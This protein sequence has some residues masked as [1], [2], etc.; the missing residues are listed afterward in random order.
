MNNRPTLTEMAEDLERQ[1]DAIDADIAEAK[2]VLKLHDD[3]IEWLE[4]YECDDDESPVA[5]EADSLTE[6]HRRRIDAILSTVTA[7]LLERAELVRSLGAV[8]DR[9]MIP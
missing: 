7:N 4:N 2:P 1:I 6:E 5:R 8:D 3:I 9:R